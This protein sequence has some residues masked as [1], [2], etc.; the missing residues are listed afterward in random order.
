VYSGDCPN[1]AQKFV[2]FREGRESLEDEPQ[3]GQPVF[4]GTIENMEKTHTTVMQDKDIT[5]R[6]LAECLGVNKEAT[7]KILERDLQ[8]RKIYSR[9]VPHSLTAEQREQQVEF[10]C[11]FVSPLTKIVMCC[12]EL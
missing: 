2:R 10:C 4:T 5:T 6:L 11:S 7:R 1:H 12:K 9:F 3:L 8:K